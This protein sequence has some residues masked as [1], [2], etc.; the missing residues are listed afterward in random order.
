[1]TLINAPYWKSGTGDQQFPDPFLDVASQNMPTT[2]KNALWWSE[3]VWGVFGTY[4]MAMER[5]VSYFLTDI[6]VTGDVSDEEK[7]K[8]T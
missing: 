3:Y 7:K 2:M 4:R 8:W 5:I 1:M 6:D